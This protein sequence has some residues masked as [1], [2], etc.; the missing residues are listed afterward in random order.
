MIKNFIYRTI[1]IVFVATVLYVGVFEL[2]FPTKGLLIYYLL[3]GIFGLVNILIYQF[4]V[5]TKESTLLKFSNRYLLCTTIKLLG[6]ILFI[7]IFLLV[8][9]EHAIPFLA[10]FLVTYIVFLIQEIIAILNFFKKNAKTESTQ[11]KT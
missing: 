9:K 11:T 3:P 8:N 10:T 4:I 1:I 7:V 5:Q 2:F 6:S